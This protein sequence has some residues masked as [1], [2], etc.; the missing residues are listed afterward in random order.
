MNKAFKKL[1]YSVKKGKVI[2]IVLKGRPQ[3]VKEEPKTGEVRRYDY[4][5]MKEAIER[6][7]EAC[8]GQSAHG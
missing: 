3:E 4:W 8:N 5:Q 7:L 1:G 2:P 6:K